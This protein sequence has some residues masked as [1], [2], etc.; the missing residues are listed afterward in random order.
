MIDMS[1][2]Q[3][4]WNKVLYGWD[5]NCINNDLFLMIDVSHWI[6]KP[7]M[8]IEEKFAQMVEQLDLKGIIFKISDANKST[9]QLFVDSTATFWYELAVKYN[10][11]RGGYHWLQASVDPTVAYKYYNGWIKDHP[12]NVPH[13]IDFEERSIKSASDILWRLEVM[14]DLCGDDSIIYTSKGYI[15]YL[16][17]MLDR[18]VWTQKISHIAQYTLWLAWY[19][20]YWPKEVWPWAKNAWQ[21]WQYSAGADYPI[22]KDQ[23][24]KD[25]L[26]WGFQ[27]HGLDMNWIKKDYYNMLI[28]ANINNNGL[29]D[30]GIGDE[31]GSGDDNTLMSIGDRVDRLEITA[32][33]HG[34]IL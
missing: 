27:A 32:R 21:V 28:S 20:R 5:L 10:L 13:I 29:D 24:N 3:K 2:W 12:L 14:L 33:S 18:S 19:S 34:W 31:P 22:Y 25:G 30:Q 26:N 6:V 8:F 11:L 23:D 16:K 17:N 9:G 15:L 7:S 1:F 4:I